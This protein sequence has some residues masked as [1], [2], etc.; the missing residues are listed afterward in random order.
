MLRKEVKDL[1]HVY[2]SSV[3]FQDCQVVM[4]IYPLNAKNV[5]ELSNARYEVVKATAK[6]RVA[7]A[8]S[9]NFL[10]VTGNDIAIDSNALLYREL[11]VNRWLAPFTVMVRG[12]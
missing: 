5:E 10:R 4:L 2:S 12:Q 11:P 7:F 3:F 1:A 9:R 8:L 6:Q